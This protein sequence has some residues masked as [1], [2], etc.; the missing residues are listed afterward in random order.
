MLHRP[1]ISRVNDTTHPVELTPDSFAPLLERA[2]GID[3][4]LLGSGSKTHQ[5]SAALKDALKQEG[6]NIETMDTGAA[7]RT[8]NVLLSEGRALAAALFPTNF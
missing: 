3:L 6:V 1:D 2:S 8:F 7:C 4:C 5:I